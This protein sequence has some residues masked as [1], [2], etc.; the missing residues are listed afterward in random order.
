MVHEI[1]QRKTKG[2][3]RTTVEEVDGVDEIHYSRKDE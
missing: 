2:I 3:Y 1:E